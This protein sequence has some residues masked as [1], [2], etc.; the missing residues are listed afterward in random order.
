[1]SAPRPKVIVTKRLTAAV[2][3]RMRALFDVTL[4]TDHRPMRREA[5]AEAVRRCDVLVPAVT[6]PIDSALIGSASERLRLIA[7]FGVGTDHVDLEAARRRGIAVTNTPDVLTEDTADLIMA[8]ILSAARGFGAGE[9]IVRA[10]AWTGWGPNN[11]LG[12]S[13]TGKAL[14]IVGMGRIGR[15]LAR[16]ARACGMEIHYHNRSRLPERDEAETAA[17]WWPELDALLASADVVSL[18][19]PYSPETHHLMDR[20]RLALMKP[21]SFLINA[22]RGGVVDE[23]A[24]LDA[25][26]SG[27]IA[28]AGLDVY[29]TEP[30]VNPRVLALENVVLL[31][32]LGSATIETRTAMGEK[33]IANIEAWV[34]GKELPDRVA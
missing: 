32:H 15:A 11:L 19:C 1:M 34:A 10:G 18:C 12:R 23:E 3:A 14:A 25:L 28:G 20:R 29:P 21:D 24:L 33:V 16:R 27:G 2:E 13:L 30:E 5:L 7:G 22:A 4:S 31:P 26:E 9:R 6:D 17:R 8:L